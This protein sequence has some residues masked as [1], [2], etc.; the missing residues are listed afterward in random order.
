MQSRPPHWIDDLNLRHLGLPALASKELVAVLPKSDGALV[1]STLVRGDLRG[2]PDQ[3]H[4]FR[5]E[6]ACALDQL[7]ASKERG[8]NDGH[9]VGC[10]EAGSIEG[11]ETLVSI[12]E[13]DQD[14]NDQ[15]DPGAVGL[16]PAGIGKLRA[17]KVLGLASPVEADVGDTDDDVVDQRRPGRDV[18]EIGEHF[19]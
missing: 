9:C 2:L 5:L 16:E 1:S 17:I 4:L 14:L 15:S 13:D 8:N 3:V 18:H 10:D 7:P 12:A 6:P 19:G 11:R